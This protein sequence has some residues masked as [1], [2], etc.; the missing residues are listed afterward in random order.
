MGTHNREQR[1]D[2]SLYFLVA[3]NYLFFPSTEEQ[4]LQEICTGRSNRVLN[5]N[6]T[7]SIVHNFSLFN[8]LFLTWFVE[9]KN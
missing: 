6:L 5:S 1:K 9:Q 7:E 8:A 4:L 2:L 3:N